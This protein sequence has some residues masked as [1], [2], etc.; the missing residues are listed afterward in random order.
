MTDGE[1]DRHPEGERGDAPDPDGLR[2]FIEWLEEKLYPALGPPPL[3]PY[4]DIVEKVGT[5]VCPVCGHAM[6]GHTIERRRDNTI[7]TCPAPH[8]VRP[9]DRRPLGETGM[10]RRMSTR[11]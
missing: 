2:G 5:A 1:V 9:D 3:G 8:L 7:L 11:A 6:E 10:P 4:D